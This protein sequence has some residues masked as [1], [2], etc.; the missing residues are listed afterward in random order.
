METKTT[1]RDQLAAFRQG[2]F[3]NSDGNEKV[4]LQYKD[5]DEKIFLSKSNADD[6][7]EIRVWINVFLSHKAG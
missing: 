5:T 2:Q 7:N 6:G 4:Y 1:L 3:I